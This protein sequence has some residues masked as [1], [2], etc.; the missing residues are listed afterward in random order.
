MNCD[1]LISNWW[2]EMCHSEIMWCWKARLDYYNSVLSGHFKSALKCLQ[3]MQKSAVRLLKGTRKKERACS[4]HIDFSSLASCEMQNWI[5]IFMLQYKTPWGSLFLSLDINKLGLN[6]NV[7]YLY[8]VYHMIRFHFYF[9]S[10][11]FHHSYSP[12]RRINT[13]LDG[14]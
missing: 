12:S 4:S 14:P 3:F 9:G 1:S 11:G 8:T 13:L 2:K 10:W 6:W 5:P 7:F